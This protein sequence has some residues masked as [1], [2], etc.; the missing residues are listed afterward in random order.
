MKLTSSAPVTRTPN[1]SVTPRSS[2][3]RAAASSAAGRR[4]ARR[5]TVTATASGSG[6]SASAGAG[7][8]RRPITSTA[9]TAS[10]PLHPVK[11]TC[12]NLR[13]P[14]APTTV[15]TASSLS[16]MVRVSGAAVSAG[17]SLVAFRMMVSSGSTSAS[18]VTVRVVAPLVAPAAIS[19]LVAVSV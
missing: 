18:S 2:R 19:M 4:S 8:N 13:A 10:V 15:V 6:L 11:P 9:A 14:A 5:F 17:L 3:P 1:A 7:A 16:A 12:N